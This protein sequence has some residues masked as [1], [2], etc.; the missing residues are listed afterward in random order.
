MTAITCVLP[1]NICTCPAPLVAYLHVVE[2]ASNENDVLQ[3]SLYGGLRS[4]AQMSSSLYGGLRYDAQ[5]SS[6]LYGGLRY[7]AQIS[8]YGGLRY[9]AQM[10]S[11]LQYM[12]GSAMTS[13]VTHKQCR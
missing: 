5:M 6:S 11:S 3:S 8:S 13:A 12:L 1:P 2:S 4:D 9:D 10:S 7:D